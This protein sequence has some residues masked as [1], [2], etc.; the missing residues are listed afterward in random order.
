MFRGW[1]I[2]HTGTSANA[3]SLK[4]RVSKPA[5]RFTT[6]SIFPTSSVGKEVA[7]ATPSPLS[8][9]GQFPILP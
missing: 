2:S 1:S 7:V 3:G 8:Q 4:A 9:R 6:D 5:P